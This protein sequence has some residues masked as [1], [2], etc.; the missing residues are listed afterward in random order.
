[1]NYDAIED[2][3]SDFFYDQEPVDWSVFSGT[4]SLC[5]PIGL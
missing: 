1:M 2:Y 4:M 5:L 3:D